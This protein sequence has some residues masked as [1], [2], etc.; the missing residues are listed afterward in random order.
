MSSGTRG[1]I[2]NWKNLC[3]VER[4]TGEYGGYQKK[5][6][7]ENFTDRDRIFLTCPRCEGILRE[8]RLSSSGEQ[9]CLS[10]MKRDE[11]PFPN[12]QVNKVVSSLK[13]C[14][15]LSR[16][17]C[18]WLG[19]LRDCEI[20]LNECDHVVQE[21]KQGCGDVLQRNEHKHHMSNTC[22]QRRVTC[23]HCLTYCKAC[24]LSDHLEECPKMKVS[25]KLECVCRKDV[26]QHLHQHCGKVKETCKLGCGVVL[27]R[28]EH[29]IHVSDSCV[30]R[31]VTCEYCGRKLKFRELSDHL[32]ECPKMK[33][34]CEL[35]CGKV[36]CREDT[37]QHMQ[38]E[39]E[40]MEVSCP[41]AKYNCVIGMIKRR[42]LKIHLD[43]EENEHTELK[44]AAMED[45]VR[46]KNEMI[47][48][49][50][51]DN[52]KQKD[53]IEGMSQLPSETIPTFSEV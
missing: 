44:L 29:R 53:L 13:C 38:E 18:E 21:C 40:E 24:H 11:H 8:S 26:T 3:L 6:L 51:K 30:Q 12:V 34:T 10:C 5:I 22:T 50:T 2:E 47:E 27:P 35:K 46:E 25:C 28:D 32:K 23:N 45:I 9:F 16:Q 41:F 33:V 31:V 1:C 39:C 37:A 15:P 17:G 4:E 52:Q 48:K 42:N 20:H 7:T 49:L 14:C 36:M 43:E 19:S